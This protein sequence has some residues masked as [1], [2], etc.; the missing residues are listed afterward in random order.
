M[1]IL[2]AA[3]LAEALAAEPFDPTT[4]LRRYE[5]NHRRQVDRRQRGVALASHLLV[6]ATR[7]GTIARNTPLRL[8]SIIAAARRASRRTDDTG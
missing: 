5:H 1:A 7:S 3:T 2:G 8:S 6:P 4:A